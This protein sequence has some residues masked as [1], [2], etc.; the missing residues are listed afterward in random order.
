[1]KTLTTLLLT[2]TVLPLTADEF[3]R[4]AWRNPKPLG[5]E[6]YSIVHAEEKF[7]AVGAYGELLSSPDGKEWTMHASPTTKRFLGVTH[8]AGLFVAF[9]RQA[10]LA[11]SPDGEHW[12]APEHNLVLGIQG[13]AY[14]ADTW[15]LLDEYGNIRSATDLTDWT[16]RVGSVLSAFSDVIF[17]QEKFVAVGNRGVIMTSTNGIDWVHQDS[18]TT[19]RLNDISHCNGRFVA[20]GNSDEEAGAGIILTSLD[21]EDWL[22]Q[23]TDFPL[24]GVGCGPNGFTVVGGTGFGF[25]CGQSLNSGDGL[26]FEP[27]PTGCDSGLTSTPNDVACNDEVCVG[28]GFGG[29]IWWTEDGLNWTGIQEGHAQASLFASAATAETLVVV[30][31]PDTILTSTDGRNFT[32]HP[33]P[34]SWRAVATDGTGFVAVGEGGVLAES[35]DGTE[36]QLIA[37]PTTSNLYGLAHG[38]A[39]WMAGGAGGVLMRKTSGSSWETLPTFGTA[40]LRRVRYSPRMNAYVA[41]TDQGMM[42]VSSDGQ[43]WLARGP[44]T[45]D[46]LQDFAESAERFIVIGTQQAFTSTDGTQWQELDTGAQYLNSLL[47]RNG[48]FVL[49]AGLSKTLLVSEDGLVWRDRS[50]GAQSLRGLAY[51]KSSFYAMGN[52]GMILQSAS[53]SVPEFLSI[54]PGGG[55]LDFELFGEIGREYELQSSPN[56]TAWEHEQDYTQSARHHPLTLPTGPDQRFYR[57]KLKE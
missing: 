37:S 15:V 28:V 20:V 13:M 38:P 23:F 18:G 32:Y 14:G 31:G 11:V 57:V 7:V 42:A 45:T 29:G 48:V 47:F 5:S 52:S 35:T 8:G 4:W 50:V 36:W 46:W 34:G 39:G 27:G 43:D 3:D 44:D 56:L 12:T 30:G 54:M 40:T 24:Y 10:N 16:L 21:A 25:G 49:G 26:Y 1:M 33:V 19:A 41:L 22:I 9:G 53:A 51:F 2:L 55:S 6:L 17:A